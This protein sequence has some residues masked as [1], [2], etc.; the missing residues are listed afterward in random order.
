MKSF[1]IKELEMLSGIKAPTIRIWEQRYAVLQPQRTGGNVR[2]YSVDDLS[3]IMN[4]ALLNGNNYKI[5]RLAKMNSDELHE[6][7][8]QLTGTNERMFKALNSLIIHMYKMNIDEFEEVLDECFL[9]WPA[10]TVVGK[11]I[12]PFLKSASLLYKG[13]RLNEEHLVV[14]AIR[15]K[16]HWCIE[17]ADTKES[18]G[19]AILLFLTQDKQLDLL[20]LCIYFHLKNAGWKV[21]YLGV[22]ISLKNIDEIASQKRFDYMLTYFP[23]KNNTSA[24][25]FSEKILSH[26]PV[27]K[28]LI[29]Q[30]KEDKVTNSTPG[31]M[32]LCCEDAIKLLCA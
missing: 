5:S 26:L 32:E 4:I 14:T 16:L 18:N 19:K 21:I 20:L 22:D 8:H 25:T 13:N 30:D 6:T 31:V 1:S 12:I 27:C 10:D 23:K 15:K 9:T 28:L 29:V 3:K 2:K 11:I 17:K 7:I 24:K